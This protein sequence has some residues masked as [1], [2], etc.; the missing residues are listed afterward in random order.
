L[1]DG[2]TLSRRFDGLPGVTD[3]TTKFRDATADNAAFSE[4][5]TLVRSMTR[6]EDLQRLLELLGQ[7]AD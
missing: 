4:I 2:T 6:S 1:R 5:P 3:P 7:D